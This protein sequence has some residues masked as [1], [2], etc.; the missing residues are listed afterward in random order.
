MLLWALLTPSSIEAG[1]QFGFN[2]NR[3]KEGLIGTDALAS[4]AGAMAGEFV[5]SG[6]QAIT[7]G[8]YNY[9]TDDI[10][11]PNRRVDGYKNQLGLGLKD[12]DLIKGIGGIV[13]NAVN[14]GVEYGISGH[15]TINILNFSDIAKAFG[16]DWFQK[17]QTDKNGKVLYVDENGNYVEQGGKI[18]RTGQWNSVGMFELTFD[19]ERGVSSR[20]GMNGIDLSIGSFVDAFRGINLLGEIST[21]DS[22][23]ENEEI[24]GDASIAEKKFKLR[25]QISFG[26]DKDREMLARIMAGKD[27][28]SIG[29]EVKNNGKGFTEV[30]NKDGSRNISAYS[31]GSGD[32]QT[33][34]AE[35]VILQHEAHR[36]GLVESDNSLETEEAVAAHTIMAMEMA[37]QFGMDFIG[38]DSNLINDVIKYAAGKDAFSKY[39]KENYDSSADY[40]KLLKNGDIVWDGSLDLNDEN[41]RILQ[42]ARYGTFATTLSDYTDMTFDES[43]NYMKQE[44]GMTFTD[45]WSLPTRYRSSVKAKV[46]I[47][48]RYEMQQYVDNVFLKYNGNMMNAVGDAE[49]DLNDEFKLLENLKGSYYSR[50]QSNEYDDFMKKYEI[51]R[52]MIDD[53]KTFGKHWNLCMYGTEDVSITGLTGGSEGLWNKDRISPQQSALINSKF[54]D[55]VNDI[56]SGNFTDSNL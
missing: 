4:Y 15:T 28:L 13:G 34:L 54:N 29:S 6:F 56:A 3:Y 43:V 14:A 19:S 22:M 30:I 5:N 1:G 36:S 25:N 33:W 31:S 48:A 41:G 7:L 27:T 26:N 20:I 47:R 23:I 49:S 24:S 46:D 11:D 44:L 8:K 39:V 9:N 45:K 12:A 21:L 52:S 16:W 42:K 53:M 40:W 51:K 17:A 55:I 37:G 35:S 18:A 38:K 2:A 50:G 32:Y 10:N